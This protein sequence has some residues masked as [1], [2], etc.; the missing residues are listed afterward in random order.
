MMQYH[1][2][3]QKQITRNLFKL[4]NFSKLRSKLLESQFKRANQLLEDLKVIQTSETT[5]LTV[6]SAFLLHR[7]TIS[8]K[9]FK[10]INQLFSQ[11][12]SIIKCVIQNLD[13]IFLILTM[14]KSFKIVI[15]KKRRLMTDI[16]TI[17]KG[18]LINSKL[19]SLEI[20]TLRRKSP[21]LNIPR[22]SILRLI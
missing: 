7:M 1:K 2:V 20:Q 11:P 12:L 13:G 21:C 15:M 16:K 10:Q 18:L 4:V 3:K 17:Y 14:L 9:V 19:S 8:Y 6:N 5:A 22:T